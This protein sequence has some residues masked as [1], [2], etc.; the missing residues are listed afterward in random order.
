[1]FKKWIGLAV[2]G[3][4]LAACSVT[5][6]LEQL[7]GTT[8]TGTDFTKALAGEYQKFAEFEAYE[9]KDWID[10]N[11]FAK[12]GLRAAGGEVVAPEDPNT[13]DQPA[14]KIKVLNSARGRLVS[15][16][17]SGGRDR[18]PAE[19]ALAQGKYDCWVEQQEENHQPEHIEK[20]QHEFIA[21]MEKLE[22]LMA[23]P[24]APPP[25]APEPEPEPAK[26]GPLKLTV[27]FDFDSS[28]LSDGANVIAKLA[29]DHLVKLGGGSISIVGHTDT[30]G[31]ADYNMG[32]SQRRAAAV[33]DALVGLGVSASAIST[34]A[35]G[36]S[37]LLD[38][39][40]DGVKS[41]QNRRATISIQ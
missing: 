19:A 39:T 12:K 21:A 15:A 8:A 24:P 3:G 17:D 27:F 18:F 35:V 1:M 14:D 25:P 9:M 34:D 26:P 4:L 37:G 7:Q 5:G 16:L 36:E 32:L 23:P 33:K 6:N 10:Q 38:E 31:S 41:P 29:A 28:N 22:G 11:Y 40:G 13:W 2:A 30:S 20:C